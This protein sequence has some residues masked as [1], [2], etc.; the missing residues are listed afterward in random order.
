MNRPDVV[1]TRVPIDNIDKVLDVAKEFDGAQFSE[2]TPAS[3]EG[4]LVQAV[5][6]HEA[7]V[8]STRATQEAS[9]PIIDALRTAVEKGV[10]ARTDVHSQSMHDMGKVAEAKREHD[11]CTGRV[12]KTEFRRAW[13]ERKL[14]VVETQVSQR[15]SLVK[16]ESSHGVNRGFS[17]VAKEDVWDWKATQQ[18][19]KSCI[20]ASQHKWD[21]DA[22]MY[23]FKY[24]EDGSDQVIKNEWA[25]SQKL[26]EDSTED[27]S[28]PCKKRRFGEAEPAKAK[29]NAKAKAKKD[30][31]ALPKLPATRRS[32]CIVSPWK[33]RIRWSQQ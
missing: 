20:A 7:E 18:I 14:K 25:A 6:L 32:R 12:A 2:K 13:A 24:V 9:N 22:K 31:S 27:A 16:Q 19:C 28:T 30:A 4:C 17:L 11:A 10:V 29:A 21:A 33:W 3:V 15:K 8:P 1:L 5:V 26:Q 23:K